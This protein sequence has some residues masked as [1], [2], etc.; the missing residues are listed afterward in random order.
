M[1]YEFPLRKFKFVV[2]C[3]NVARHCITLPFL[4]DARRQ[5]IPGEGKKKK[6]LHEERAANIPR[7]AYVR[8]FRGES[9]LLLITCRRRRYRAVI[10]V[11]PRFARGTSPLGPRPRIELPRRVI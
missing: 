10:T 2:E 4:F 11:D 9:A 5:S 8:S 6:G 3:I 7:A 1:N